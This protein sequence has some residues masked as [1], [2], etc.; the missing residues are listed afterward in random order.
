MTLEDPGHAAEAQIR[1]AAKGW[2]LYTVFSP[3]PCAL[4][5]VP[6]AYDGL[7]TAGRHMMLKTMQNLFCYTAPRS[8]RRTGRLNFLAHLYHL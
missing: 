3:H 5:L 7:Q 2:G 4:R 1:V 8:S 6:R